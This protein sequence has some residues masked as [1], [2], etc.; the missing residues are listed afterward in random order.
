MAWR[1]ITEDDVREKLTDAELAAVGGVLY[2]G[3]TSITNK[4]RG[5]VASSGAEMDANPATLPDRLIGDA[6]AVLIVDLYIRLGGTLVDPKGHRK[7]SKEQALR[8]FGRVADGK[9]SI[10]D[11]TSGEESNASTTP[12]YK[13]TRTRQFDRRSQD[14]I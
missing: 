8:L 1:E 4:V 5:Y 7:D 6:C 3:I 10:E 11:P 14:G 12:T 9:Y 2:E 13:P